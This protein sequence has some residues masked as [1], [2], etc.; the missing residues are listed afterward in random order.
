M[1]KIMTKPLLEEWREKD[2]GHREPHKFHDH[3]KTLALFKMI[4]A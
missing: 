3:K 2:T 1:R 4:N